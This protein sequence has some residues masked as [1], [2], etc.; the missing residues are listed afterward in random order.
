M[1]VGAAAGLETPA[2][3]AHLTKREPAS[4]FWWKEVNVAKDAA[5]R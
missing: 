1:D 3:S 4:E 5:S 2:P